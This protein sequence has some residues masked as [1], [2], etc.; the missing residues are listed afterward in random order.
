MTVFFLKN[1]AKWAKR[2]RHDCFF[3]NYKNIVQLSVT[4]IPYSPDGKIDDFVDIGTK[5]AST[6]YKT[7]LTSTAFQLELP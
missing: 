5:A 6:G 3:Y 7:W 4:L 1:I 2:R